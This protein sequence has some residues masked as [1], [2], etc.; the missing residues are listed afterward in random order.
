M[1]GFV[2]SRLHPLANL[3][4][5]V[6]LLLATFCVAS[7]LVM[8]LNY[9]AFGVGMQDMGNVTQRPADYPNGWAVSMLSQGVLLLGGL[10]GAALALAALTGNKLA[11]YF[12]PRR[13]VPA[14]WPLLAGLLIVAS[15]PAMSV[16]IAWNASWGLPEWAMTKEQQAK[17]IL[18]F[19]TNFS[20]P[21]RFGVAVLVMAVVPAVSEELFFRGVLQRNLVQ[22]AGRHVGIWLA[23]IV[24]SAIHLQ[25]QGFVPRFVLGLGLGYLYEWSRNILVPI[26]AHFAQNGFQLLLLYLQQRDWSSSGFDPDSTEALPWYWVLLS[27]AVCTVGLWYLHRRM[28]APQADALPTEMHTLGSHGVAVSRPALV[29]PAA[30]TLS[31]DGVDATKAD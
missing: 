3:G 31:H 12:M 25:F 2:S 13:P 14:G 9:L 26:A 7:F 27:M 23:A 16:L 15:L 4:L 30:R 28:S 17:D 5:L 8:V 19:L 6:V 24:F 20:S 21:L 11:D 29:P 1:K 18:K 22:W 10:G